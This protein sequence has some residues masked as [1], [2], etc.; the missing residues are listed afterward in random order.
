MQ[1]LEASWNYE[2]PKAA[3]AQGMVKFLERPEKEG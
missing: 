1:F 2:A 3:A